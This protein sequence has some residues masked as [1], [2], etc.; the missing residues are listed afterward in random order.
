MEPFHLERYL[1]EQAFRFNHRKLTDGER[2]TRALGGTDGERL[3]Y[4]ELI[5]AEPHKRQVDAVR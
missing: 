4:A 2:F 1:D 3:T 5:G